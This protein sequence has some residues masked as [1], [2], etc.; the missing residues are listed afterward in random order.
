LEWLNANSLRNYPF[1]E[2]AS[3]VPVDAGGNP[4]PDLQLP[5]YLLVDFVMMM[6]STLMVD[7][8]LSQLAKVG[9]LLTFIFANTGGTIIATLAVDYSVHQTYN[10]YEIVGVG[11]Y[12]DVRGKVV[13]GD[14][15]DLNADLAE[16]LY[17]F[18]LAGAKFESTTVRPALRGV[19]SLQLENDT[20]LSAYIYGHVKLLNGAN[21]QLT[22]LPAYNAI[23]ID[24]VSGAGLNESCECEGTQGWRNVVRMINGIAVENFELVGDGT[25]VDVKT[26]G[27]KL[28]ISDTCSA[29]CCGCPE[30]EFLTDSLKVLEATIG[31]LESYANQL[32]AQITNFVS[33]FVLTIGT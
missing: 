31:N 13:L 7:V 30:L 4:I 16:G 18:Q 3:L 22:Y 19:R 1:K 10:S 17:T 20:V 11:G 12:N 23:R 26:E 15:R 29:P 33:T 14:L 21:I 8:Y 28:V 2:D 6:P 24:A 27:N 25:C 32:Q 5:N 9:N